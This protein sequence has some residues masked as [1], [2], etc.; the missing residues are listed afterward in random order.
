VVHQRIFTL[1]G[2]AEFLACKFSARAHTVIGLGGARAGQHAS[3]CSRQ[4]YNQ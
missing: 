3:I 1:D 2:G 4:R